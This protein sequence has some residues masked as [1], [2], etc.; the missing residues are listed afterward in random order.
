MRSIKVHRVRIRYKEGGESDKRRPSP[1]E[2]GW[3]AGGRW[4]QC[5]L[6]AELD[7]C[8]GEIDAVESFPSETLSRIYAGVLGEGSEGRDKGCKC[9][10]DATLH[11]TMNERSSRFPF[12]LLFFWDDGVPFFLNSA[13]Y[14]GSPSRS[15]GGAMYGFNVRAYKCVFNW[16]VF[17]SWKPET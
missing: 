16:Y 14:E 11:S 12:P 3:A 13:W 9:L 7:G 15:C 6:R 2:S 17:L 8:P 10:D 5:G 4:G 1:S